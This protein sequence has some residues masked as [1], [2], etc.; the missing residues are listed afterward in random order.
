MAYSFFWKARSCVWSI[1]EATIISRFVCHSPLSL[2][3]EIRT[4]VWIAAPSFCKACV[5]TS[6]TW[7]LH[8][9]QDGMT[10]NSKFV[11]K[12]KTIQNS[13][14]E[15][16]PSAKMETHHKSVRLWILAPHQWSAARQ[17]FPS[18]VS[19]NLGWEVEAAPVSAL[20][21]P[22]SWDTGTGELVWSRGYELTKRSL[23]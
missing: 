6:A 14:E 3:T 12:M 11:T 1:V 21:G 19:G 7:D 9:S 2:W 13:Q 5:L 16:E 23:Y 22:L 20:V 15:K 4:G 10:E 18:W 8:R 17:D